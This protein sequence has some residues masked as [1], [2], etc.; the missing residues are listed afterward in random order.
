MQH[1]LLELLQQQQGPR[2]RTFMGRFIPPGQQPTLSQVLSRP[3]NEPV[4]GEGM[5]ALG[6]MGAGVFGAN[7]PSRVGR[8]LTEVEKMRLYL[9]AVELERLQGQMKKIPRQQVPQHINK[10]DE[11]IEEL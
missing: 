9:N 3:A 2:G 11:I 7:M 6:V 1:T 8:P 10:M 4:E 5:G